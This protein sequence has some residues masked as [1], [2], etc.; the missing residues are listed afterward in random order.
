MITV[1]RSIF[2]YGQYTSAWPSTRVFNPPWDR[3][4]QKTDRVGKPFATFV[5]ADGDGMG[6]FGDWC[7][8]LKRDSR[9]W[10]MA[11]F[12]GF[13]CSYLDAH[14]EWVSFAR[15]YGGEYPTPSTITWCATQDWAR[16]WE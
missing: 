5:F 4:A 1:N 9:V 7:F 11:H 6:V 13:N 8:S 16:L 12:E 2:P 14:V 15:H 10:W 3:C